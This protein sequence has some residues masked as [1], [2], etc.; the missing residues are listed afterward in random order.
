MRGGAALWRD[1]GRSIPDRQ[2]DPS[3]IEWA[4]EELSPVQALLLPPSP[5]EWLPEDH[6]AYFVLDLLADMDLGLIER[7]LQGKDAR[8]ERT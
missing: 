6:R 4:G 5:N 7:S 8:G 1:R 3:W 2:I